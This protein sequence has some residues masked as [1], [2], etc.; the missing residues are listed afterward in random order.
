LLCLTTWKWNDRRGFRQHRA[1][2]DQS[3]HS[4]DRRLV[5]LL[6]RPA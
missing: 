3:L 5:R 4:R 2:E 1:A 6:L